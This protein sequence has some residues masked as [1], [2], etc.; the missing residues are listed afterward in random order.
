MKRVLVLTVFLLAAL[1]C[2]A[3]T[4]NQDVNAQANQIF[5]SVMSPYCP[6]RLLINCPSSGATELKLKITEMV[7]SGASSEGILEHLVETYGPSVRAA[8]QNSGFGRLAWLVP[9]VFL[10]LGGLV[11]FFWLRSNQSQE[12]ISN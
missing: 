7:R 2:N 3:Q 4:P 9:F 5:S 1:I 6:G 10:G 11:I 8:P 12:K